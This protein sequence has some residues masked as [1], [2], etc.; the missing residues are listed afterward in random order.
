MGSRTTHTCNKYC[1]SQHSVNWRLSAVRLWR[2][3]CNKFC[4]FVTQASE[5]G[6][7][8]HAHDFIHYIH[9]I[10][11]QYFG[12]MKNTIN[13]THFMQFCSA[14]C[15]HCR[16]RLFS[17]IACGFLYAMQSILNTCVKCVTKHLTY[18]ENILLYRMGSVE[19]HWWT[20]WKQQSFAYRYIAVYIMIPS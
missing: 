20:A 2:Q 4:P 15:K 19:G 16:C 12:L 8:I 1:F 5:L 10:C 7:V 18:V 9:F 11:H 6:T 14:L 13:L 17:P 3:S